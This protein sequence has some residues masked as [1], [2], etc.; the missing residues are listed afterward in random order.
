[1]APR[2]SDQGARLKNSHHTRTA[3]AHTRA[4]ITTPIPA[5]GATIGRP[6][7]ISHIS[8]TATTPGHSRSGFRG[9]GSSV[10]LMGI[11]ELC[12]GSSM[13]LVVISF[14]PDYVPRLLL[15]F[16]EHVLLPDTG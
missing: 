3:N 10:L 5:S 11:A 2:R 15:L 1:M 14:T 4:P 6:N 16:L 7:Q 12:C 9:T 8:A 13:L